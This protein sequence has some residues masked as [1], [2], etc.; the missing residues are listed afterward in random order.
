MTLDVPDDRVFTKREVVRWW[1]LRRPLFNL[2][3]LI[4][5]LSSIAAM[6][7]LVAPLLPERQDVVEAIT[8]I[9]VVAVYG[10][11]VNLCYT[12]G[13]ILELRE[14]K[15]DARMARERGRLLFQVMLAFS[16]IL[17][18]GP[19]WYGCVFWMMHRAESR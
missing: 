10:V 16:L 1:E 14:R 9:L 2:G 15:E 13:W 18:S 11:L 5:G 17:A 12:F 3:V 4:V 6:E 8:L 7:S 19:F